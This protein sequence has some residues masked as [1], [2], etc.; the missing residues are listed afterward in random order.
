M[1]NLPVEIIL[2]IVLKLD[3]KNLGNLR[4]VNRALAGAYAEFV[5]QNGISIM[6]ATRWLEDLE[7]FLTQ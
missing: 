7:C 1:I 4:L 6:N 5:V 2:I 3:A